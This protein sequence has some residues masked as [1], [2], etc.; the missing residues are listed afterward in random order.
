[1]TPV[2]PGRAEAGRQLKSVMSMSRAPYGD[3]VTD[4][5]VP[6]GFAAM[7]RNRLNADDI[8][9]DLATELAEYIR[10][11]P[12]RMCAA[13]TATFEELDSCGTALWNAV[14]KIKTQSSTPEHQ[15]NLGLGMATAEV[16]CCQIL[17]VAVRV[18]AFLLLDSG[19]QTARGTLHSTVK[20]LRYRLND[21]IKPTD[22]VRVFKVALKSAKHCIGTLRKIAQVRCGHGLTA[23]IVHKQNEIALHVLERAAVYQEAVELS[24]DHLSPQESATH[25]RLSWDYFILRTIQVSYGLPMLRTVKLTESVMA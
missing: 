6:Q 1:M 2:Q 22:A 21:L 16:W 19:Q 10:A 13:A 11:L 5:G 24:R 8:S 3:Q 15:K 25:A 23:S 14:S 17:T 18:F 9:P 4:V 20:P 7:L 12:G